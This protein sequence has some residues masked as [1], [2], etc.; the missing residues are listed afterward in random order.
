VEEAGL[1]LARDISVI[2]HDD[3]LSYLRNG[4]EVPTF[5]AMRSSVRQAGRLC[6]ERLIAMIR[7]PGG[8]AQNTLLEAEFIPGQ[9]TGPAPGGATA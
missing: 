3:E 4:G 5:T 9:S 2:T 6:A 8:P 7:T 1:R